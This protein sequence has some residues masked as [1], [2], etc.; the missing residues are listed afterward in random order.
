MAAAAT[1]VGVPFTDAIVYCVKDVSIKT[2]EQVTVTAD[3]IGGFMGK[4][5]RFGISYVENWA[6]TGTYPQDY[7]KYIWV[8]YVGGP[9]NPINYI[10]SSNVPTA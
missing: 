1:E 8:L 2:K 9:K 4:I 10:N 6:A 7:N 3:E 5:L